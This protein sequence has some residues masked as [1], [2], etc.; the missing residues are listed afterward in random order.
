MCNFVFFIFNILIFSIIIRSPP[1]SSI[2]AN[3]GADI[4][5]FEDQISNMAMLYQLSGDTSYCTTVPSFLKEISY[6]QIIL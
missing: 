1:P 6:Y 4:R 3:G 5:G 2:E